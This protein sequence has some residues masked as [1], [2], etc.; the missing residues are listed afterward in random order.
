MAQPGPRLLAATQL[1]ISELT[2][3]LLDSFP[4]LSLTFSNMIIVRFRFLYF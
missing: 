4:H 1:L 3:L 2:T